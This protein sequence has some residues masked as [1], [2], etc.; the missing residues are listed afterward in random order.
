VRKI[1]TSV[2]EALLQ[3][4]A[5]R[6]V[7]VEQ[8]YFQMWW[9]EQPESVRDSVRQLVKGGSFVPQS[10]FCRVTLTVLLQAASCSSPTVAG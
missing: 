7:Y 8:V 9:D 10:H 5:R 2:V 1:I 6:F 3:D 4:S